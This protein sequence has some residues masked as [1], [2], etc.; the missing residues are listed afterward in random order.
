MTG[1]WATSATRTATAPDSVAPMTGMNAPRNTR[2]ASGS[3]SGM[4]RT[5]SPMPMPTASTNATSTVARTYETR[6]CQE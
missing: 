3:A 5:T 2:A 4:R 1:P 6:V